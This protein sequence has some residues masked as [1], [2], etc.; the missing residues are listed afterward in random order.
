MTLKFLARR[1][2]ELQR[3]KPVLVRLL[4]KNGIKKAG[5]FGSYAR[6]E[7]TKKSDIDI[8]IEPYKGMGLEFVGLVFD[9]EKELGRK[10]DLVTYGSLHPLLK[11][12]I[13]KDEVRII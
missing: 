1:S 11:K 2:S 4:K 8:I 3:M 12:S 13:L 10:V 7:Q 6:G 9:L 5:V